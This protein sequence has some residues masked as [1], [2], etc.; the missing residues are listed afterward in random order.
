MDVFF[1]LDSGE[2]FWHVTGGERAQLRRL[3]A[4]AIADDADDEIQVYF[5]GGHRVGSDPDY[6]V[7]LLELGPPWLV[8]YIK[9]ANGAA[10]DAWD[11]QQS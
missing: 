4:A 3:I 5:E 7:W 10:R 1:S 9:H 11:E 6:S 2:L 8:V